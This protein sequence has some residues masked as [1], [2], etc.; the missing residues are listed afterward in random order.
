MWLRVFFAAWVVV[1]TVISTAGV[2]R[3]EFR[4]DAVLD[5]AAAVVASLRT[6]SVEANFPPSLSI[7]DEE[8]RRT[9]RQ[10]YIWGWPLVYVHNCCKTFE[11]VPAPG[12][13]GGMPVAPPN[14]LSMLTDYISPTQ[15]LVPCPNQDVVY[16]F[17]VLNL[18]AEPVVVQVPDF[19]D[20]FWVYQLG[21]QRTDGFA[22]VGK[23]YA[24]RPGF[25]LLV[26]PDWQGATP[27]GI[28]GV[29]RS[30]TNL[31]YC[32]PRVFLNDTTADRDAVR[33]LVNQIMMYPL[34]RF[35]G[36][37]KTTDWTKFRW[38]P[39]V[40]SRGGR[41]SRWVVPETFFDSLSDVLAEVP[42]L[43]GEEAMY[44]RFKQ[45][46]ATARRDP[47]VKDLL[48]QTALLAEERIVGP[49][50]EFQNLG[51][52]VAHHW[53]TIENGA[54]FGTDYL[55]R[56]AVAKSNVY[57]NRNVETK[58]YYQDFDAGGRRLDG[59]RSFV[60]TFPAGALPPAKGFWSLTLYD[61]NHA[62]YQN[63]L[64]RY[65]LGTKNDGLMY[66]ADGSLTFLI[67]HQPPAEE[68]RSNWIPAPSG[69][70]SLYLRA[71]APDAPILSGAWTPPP[72]VSLDTH[73]AIGN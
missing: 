33:S 67:Q 11:K 62:F 41:Q 36:Q 63:D 23:M 68:M 25:Y 7:S 30:S 22:E 51:K 26:G 53:R 9:A 10:A 8:V 66:N 54:A 52:R 24:T 45:L 32:I 58:Y 29:F 50:F 44:A 42:P 3:T 61:D 72:V 4:S 46:L 2:V 38:I 19:G 55:T 16:G 71:Y 28:A 1:G 59:S 18:A 31:G 70:F 40:G 56:T 13:S 69:A 35:N 65:S 43:A 37:V 6:H 27:E 57:V 34:S 47:A 39:Q 20:R 73:V 60:V 12:R 21:D 15:M 14:Q 5:D 49:M 64:K 17:G 48:V